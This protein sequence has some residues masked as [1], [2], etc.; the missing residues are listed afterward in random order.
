MTRNKFPSHL[1]EVWE[2]CNF[3]ETLRD[4]FRKTGLFPFDANII[5]KTVT[6]VG[7]TDEPASP[8]PLTFSPQ[9]R[10]L[11]EV[12]EDMKVPE[13]SINSIVGQAMRSARGQTIGYDIAK[14]LRK[15][16]LE[17]NPKKQR[18]TKD[19]RLGTTSGLILT[20]PPSVAALN[21]K[22]SS[23]KKPATRR[24]PAKK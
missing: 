1:L 7:P 3:S 22:E 15:A 18:V 13:D 6:S 2:K 9:K 17:S 5:L 8:G 19:Q 11:R 21:D 23:K 20:L 14:S 10:K 24:R 12:L 4:G 16:L